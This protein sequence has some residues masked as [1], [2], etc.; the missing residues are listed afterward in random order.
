MGDRGI[1][2]GYDAVR[3]IQNNDGLFI[4]ASDATFA[5]SACTSG[6]TCDTFWP[7]TLASDCTH[8][9]ATSKA[10]LTRTSMKFSATILPYYASGNDHS[11]SAELSLN[12]QVLT[13]TAIGTLIHIFIW[14]VQYACR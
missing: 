1:T 7:Y 4:K 2:T 6:A 8:N 5:R 9:L 11:G 14:L 13:V 3:I 12:D 10:D